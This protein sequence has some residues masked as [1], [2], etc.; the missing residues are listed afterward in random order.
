MYG[1][2]GGMN[3]L[4]GIKWG[5]MLGAHVAI[6][7]SPC[8]VAGLVRTTG[9]HYGSVMAVIRE[10]ECGK[11]SWCIVIHH[12]V[13][14]VGVS[15]D[16][17]PVGQPASL[18]GSSTRYNYCTRWMALTACRFHTVCCLPANS[19]LSLL[20]AYWGSLKPSLDLLVDVMTL[21]LTYGREKSVQIPLPNR[22]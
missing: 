3:S 19:K 13:Y 8:L 14:H 6:I 15:L 18:K 12:D 2:E 7:M 20:L 1:R 9:L 4:C 10:S 16:S 17:Q 22:A 11:Q 5:N 21:S